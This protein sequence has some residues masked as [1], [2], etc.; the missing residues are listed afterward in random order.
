[1]SGK[2]LVIDPSE[3]LDLIRGLASEVRVSILKLLRNGQEKNVNQIAEQLGLPQS[4]VSSNLQILEDTG[5]VTTESRKARK[6][7][8]KV[9]RTALRRFS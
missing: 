6:G 5:L 9:C 7:S 4:T 1:M 2:V 3:R 8:Q